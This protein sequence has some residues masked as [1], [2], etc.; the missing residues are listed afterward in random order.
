MGES[1]KLP[2]T[3]Q[4]NFLF[5]YCNHYFIFYTIFSRLVLVKTELR[6]T[7][8]LELQKKDEKLLYTMYLVQSKHTFC[9]NLKIS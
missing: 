3:C 1:E 6:S 8:V 9:K 4:K 7:E 2:Y 5:F